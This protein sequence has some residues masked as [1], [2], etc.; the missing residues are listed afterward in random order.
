MKFWLNVLYV[1]IVYKKDIVTDK[2][3]DKEDSIDVINM[4]SKVKEELE[5]LFKSPQEEQTTQRNENH[6]KLASMEKK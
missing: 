3:S 5:M 2:M 4:D 6:V 1:I